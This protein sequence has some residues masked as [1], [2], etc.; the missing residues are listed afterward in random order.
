MD[1]KLRVY[2]LDKDRQAMRGSVQWISHYRRH[3]KK[4]WLGMVEGAL[5]GQNL[6]GSSIEQR[7]LYSLWS[8]S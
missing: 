1:R 2:H 6:H 7:L 8:V 3:W 5:P 4:A